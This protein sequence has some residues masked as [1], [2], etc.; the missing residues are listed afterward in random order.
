MRKYWLL[1]PIENVFRSV[2]FTHYLDTMHNH[3]NSPNGIDIV[4]VADSEFEESRVD[5]YQNDILIGFSYTV[6]ED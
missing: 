5:I 4:T 3:L 2:S 6:K 1:D